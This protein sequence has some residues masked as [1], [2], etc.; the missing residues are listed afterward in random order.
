MCIIFN[1]VLSVTLSTTMIY[2][3]ITATITIAN[4]NHFVEIT[5]VV[6]RKYWQTQKSIRLDAQITVNGWLE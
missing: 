2:A 5:F 1:T 3:V 6:Y 4:S